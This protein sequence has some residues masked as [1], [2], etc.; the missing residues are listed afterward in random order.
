MKRIKHVLIIAEAGSNWRLGT[1]SRDVEMA[2]TLIDVA[3][4]SGAD[5]VKFQTYQ[6][7]S[8]YAK[9]AGSPAYLARRGLTESIE[10]IFKD[11][12]MPHEMISEISSYCNSS[13][14]QFMSTP[15][16]VSDAEAIDPYV[17]IHKIASYEMSHV[18][19]LE[20]VAKTG[21]PL[22]LS[23]GAASNKEIEWAVNY[24]YKVGGKD[25]SLLQ[26]TAK[27]PAE[28]NLLNLNVIPK[29][30]Q[31]YRI[32]VGLSDHSRDPIIAPVC[33]VALGATI[34]E[35][36]YTLSNKLPGPDHSFA[37]IPSELNSMV[38]AIRKAEIALGSNLKVVQKEEQELRRFAGRSIQATKAIKMHEK[39]VEGINIDILRPGNNSQG[40]DPKYIFEVH[41]KK[42]TRN[43]ELGE[44]ITQGDFE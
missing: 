33:A 27:Y 2:K 21:K 4:E 8:V 43:I 16:S 37:I 38:D 18:R 23:T 41:G 9:G 32:P 28:L 42:A 7:D 12:A 22:I 29:M 20:F 31:Q 10:K 44:G 36:H 3:A 30:I 24:F 40:L 11:H 1:Y 17:K 35:K 6:A 14:I 15:F 25:I 39:L 13:G 5:A 34:I 19:L 26:N